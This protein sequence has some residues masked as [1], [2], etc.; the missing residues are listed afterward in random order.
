MA[1][2][3]QTQSI[4]EFLALIPTSPKPP[5]IVRC[6]ESRQG[7]AFFSPFKGAHITGIAL[8][9]YAQFDLIALITDDKRAI[10]VVADRDGFIAVE[11]RC[12]GD[13]TGDANLAL[14][15]DISHERINSA[16]SV[17]AKDNITY[18]DDK[19][20]TGET[21]EVDPATTFANVSLRDGVEI[22]SI[23]P[24]WWTEDWMN[25]W[26]PDRR[27]INIRAKRDKMFGAI[28]INDGVLNIL[29]I[30]DQHLER[31]KLD[32]PPLG[33]IPAQFQSQNK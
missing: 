7:E 19:P 2:E 22:K 29:N 1:I 20:I 8:L 30:G 17:G 14:Q 13:G 21:I 16:A 24:T 28:T 11:K 27:K 25:V 26:S 23:E 33:S 5:S 6:V 12:G 10:A 31:L 3:T 4:N 32:Q 15:S 18:Q 9:R